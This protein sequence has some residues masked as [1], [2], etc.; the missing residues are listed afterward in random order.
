MR[1]ITV[2]LI[3]V[4]L[5][6]SFFGC[7]RETSDAPLPA[8]SAPSIAASPE[9]SAQAN[10]EETPANIEGLPDLSVDDQGRIVCTLDE[11]EFQLPA[12]LDDIAATFGSAD[13]KALI[14]ITQIPPL[15]YEVP[16]TFTS[17]DFADYT[18]LE[19]PSFLP[20]YSATYVN[21][22]GSV[23]IDVPAHLKPDSQNY[24]QYKIIDD[25]GNTLECAEYDMETG[26]LYSVAVDLL[27]ENYVPA[28]AG[29]PA[30][31]ETY[32][33]YVNRRYFYDDAGA[34]EQII[35]MAQNYCYFAS[36]FVREYCYIRDFYYSD[37]ML[38]SNNGAFS[39]SFYKDKDRL[40]WNTG[41][42]HMRL[43]ENGNM[44]AVRCCVNDKS[45]TFT[46]SVKA[47]T[48]GEANIGIPS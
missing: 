4:L 30:D 21:T 9:N 45:Y 37:G 10:A 2:V 13:I 40:R 19:T 38:S 23:Q 15:P 8:T 43:D 16:Q 14:A 34:P 22:D 3:S 18:L 33:R 24:Y 32:T 46:V 17:D 44:N 11:R 31:E 26:K 42:L 28:E 35:F 41:Q 12:N 27:M 25:A 36:G 20:L 39:C 6:A 5:S 29:R 48:D 1:R 7:V 47:W